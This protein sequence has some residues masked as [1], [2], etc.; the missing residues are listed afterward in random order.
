MVASV[1]ERTREHPEGVVRHYGQAIKPMPKPKI[2]WIGELPDGAE[3]RCVGG[4]A[5]GWGATPRL[6]YAQWRANW[7]SRERYWRGSPLYWLAV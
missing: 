7:E 1:H 2:H 4:G 3:W 6:A 5:K